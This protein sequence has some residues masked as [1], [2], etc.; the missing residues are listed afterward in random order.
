MALNNSF[1]V[2]TD[3]NGMHNLVIVQMQW[4]NCLDFSNGKCNISGKSMKIFEMQGF[5]V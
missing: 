4:F 3:I 2:K 1:L 5:N